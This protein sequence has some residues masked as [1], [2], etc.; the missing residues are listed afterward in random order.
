MSLLHQTYAFWHLVLAI[1]EA[2]LLVSAYSFLKLSHNITAIALPFILLSTIYDNVILFSGKYIGVGSLLESLSVQRYFLHY[3]FVPLLIVVAIELAFVA[4]AKWA[5][6]TVRVLSWLLAGGIAAY[7][8]A[9]NFIGLELKPVTFADVL[10]YTPTVLSPPISTIAIS[11]FVCFVAVGIRVRTKSW[12]WLLA[13]STIAL[14]TGALP[15]RTYGTLPGSA[16]ECLLAL[17]LLLT[18]YQF[19]S[20]LEV[21]PKY[22]STQIAGDG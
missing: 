4:G 5:N 20:D 11:V 1:I 9:T 18:Q 10:R 3:A 17:G 8:L 12:S 15:L 19:E 6:Q 13:G 14:I 22:S 16:G 21:A 7:D 2:L